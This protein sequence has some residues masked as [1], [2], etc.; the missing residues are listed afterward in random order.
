MTPTSSPMRLCRSVEVIDPVEVVPTR[1]GLSSQL[2]SPEFTTVLDRMVPDS[3]TG[4]R[5][6]EA[7]LGLRQLAR[8]ALAASRP[9]AGG[10]LAGHGVA[11]GACAGADGGLL[12]SAATSP[13]SASSAVRSSA[14]SSRSASISVRPAEAVGTGPGP[15]AGIAGSV[16]AGP[17]HASATAVRRI[18]AAAATAT[19]RPGQA[20]ELVPSA[21]L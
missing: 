14:I 21:A 2:A 10:R 11:T 15:I 6:P 17:G 7:T 18:G 3:V 5:E 19:T 13:R 9:A 16:L 12:R 1:F 8:P 4:K 20:K